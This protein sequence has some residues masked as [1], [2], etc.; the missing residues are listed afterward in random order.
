MLLLVVLSCVLLSALKGGLGCGGECVNKKGESCM[1][2]ASMCVV[3]SEVYGVG[4]AG[5][6]SK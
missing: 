5:R 3:G 2:V 4:D 1:D 6:K